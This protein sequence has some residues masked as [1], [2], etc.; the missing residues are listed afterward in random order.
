DVKKWWLWGYWVSPMMYGQNAIAVNEFLGKSWA[1]IPLNSTEPLGVQILKSRGLF[2][3]A[4]WYWIGVG[5]SIGYMFLFNFL[6]PLALHYLDSFGKP[7]ALISEE[8]LAER[9]AATSENKQIIEL[10]SK[11]ECSSS[12][13]KGNT[14]TSQRSFSSTTQS[15]KV[16]SISA[17]DHSRKRGMVLPFT[18]LSITFDE[19]GYE[20]DMP[21]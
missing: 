18:P 11:L 4:Y 1:H 6:F 14:N 19:I 13:A 2:P 12:S 15:A 3:E 8:A 17:A 9:N 10:S 21:Q 5:A 16:G 7:Q 20:V